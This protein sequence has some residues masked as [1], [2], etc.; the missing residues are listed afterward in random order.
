MSVV[1]NTTT[2]GAIELPSRRNTELLLLAFAVV[3]PIFAYANAGL[4]IHGKLP[5]GML[6]YGL[7]LG[8]LAGIAHLVVRRYAK[9]A[10]PLL[11]P[12]ATLLNGLGLVL[13]WRLDQST[14]LQNTAKRIYGTFSESAP[15]QMMYT[16]LAI[17]LFAG[18]LLVL[19]D[20]R[21]LQRF[22]YISMAAALVLLILPVVPAWAPTSSAPRS[23]SASAGS[24]SSPASSRRSS[25]PSSSPATSWSSATPWPW[26]AAASWGSTCRAAATSDRS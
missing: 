17:A 10:D 21:V 6:T 5:P 13:I 22:T 8:V 25:S 20:H 15:R 18:V 3:I 14:R 4:S 9:Y 1:T 19:K 11:L 16:A 2:I 12:I 23:G 24:P 7:G 26:P